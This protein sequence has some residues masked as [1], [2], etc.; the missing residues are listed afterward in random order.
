MAPQLAAHLPTQLTFGLVLYGKL[1]GWKIAASDLVRGKRGGWPGQACSRCGR[2]GTNSSVDTAQVLAETRA[3]ARFT[4]SSLWK[5]VVRPNRA[6]G[7]RVVVVVHTWNPEVGADLDG[8]YT[9]DASKHEQANP[10]LDKLASQ[11]L[12]IQRA[13][14][15]LDALPGPVPARVMVTRLDLL[16]FTDVPL[17]QTLGAPLWLPHSCVSSVHLHLPDEEAR[18]EKQRLSLA[19]GGKLGGRRVQPPQLTRFSA[20]LKLDRSR[21]FESYVLDY[22]FISSVEIARGFAALADPSTRESYRREIDRRVGRGAPQWAH[23]YWAH[24]IRHHLGAAGV[25]PRWLLQH[26]VD[27]TLARYWRNAADCVAPVPGGGGGGGGGGGITGGPEVSSGIPAAATVTGSPGSMGLRGSTG[28]LD[29]ARASAVVLSRL[30]PS[31]YDFSLQFRQAQAGAPNGSMTPG[32]ARAPDDLLAPQCPARFA[33]GEAILCQWHK[34]VCSG[35]GGSRVR[36]MLRMADGAGRFQREAGLDARQLF[37]A[38]QC[39]SRECLEHTG[40]AN[41]VAR[42]SLAGTFAGRRGRGERR[43]GGRRR[44]AENL[45]GK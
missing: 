10:S 19:C 38:E 16:L 15:M 30:T 1:G 5:H 25:R 44:G 33:T 3:F 4:H 18:A 17:R 36:Q 34:P 29:L 13:I 9:P 43:K 8:L 32:G 27:F 40:T 37:G 31:L 22:F 28:L 39:T 41:A 24:H 7:A 14:G 6:A 35:S 42:R 23:V 2:R 20:R 12:S 11:H 26:E 21:D 45:W